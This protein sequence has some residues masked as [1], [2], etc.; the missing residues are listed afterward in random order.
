M[1]CQ[2]PSVTAGAAVAAL[3]AASALSCSPAVRDLSPVGEVLV[4]VDTDMPV[5]TVI[6]R[7]RIDLYAPDGSWF[8]SR[9]V[10]R[11]RKTDWPTSFGV[12]LPDPSREGSVVVRLR[13]YLDGEVRD[14]RG[15][16]YVAP[17]SGGKPFEIAAPAGPVVDARL[18]RADGSDATPKTE[19]EP[20]TTIDRL[21]LVRVRPDV[22]AGVR[23]VL[24]G[25]CVGT[26]A[27]VAGGQSCTD[28][29][30]IVAPIT[31]EPTREDTSLAP[32]SVAGTFGTAE[33][34]TAATR[35]AGTA[36]DGT[37]LHDDDVCV[38]G[39]MFVYGSK[40]AFGLGEADDVPRRV[41]IVP[42]FRIDRYE[43][44][45]GRFRAAVAKGFV[46]PTAPGVALTGNDAPLATVGIDTTSASLC[47]WS[48]A[49]RG[50][51]TF[52]I[53]CLAW[54]IARAFCK[55]DGGDLPSE[56]QW[57]YVAANAGRPFQSRYPWGGDDRTVV[58]CEQTAFGRGP[59]PFDNECNMDG[60]TF[61]LLPVGS[62]TGALADV[63]V[64]LG[65]VDLAGGLSE[66]TADAFAS[67]SSNCWTS[68]PL[69][70]PAC[71]VE[72]APTHTARGGN[73]STSRQSLFLAFRSPFP[74]KGSSPSVGFRCVHPGQ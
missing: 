63:S 11:S 8:E 70:A 45:V 65:V 33:R 7:L 27:D 66:F 9:D 59:Y 49:P 44:T 73:W 25:A 4:I 72:P 26:M 19:P 35:A 22:H 67:L 13:G 5:P 47:T 23:V 50:R 58:R 12:F 54:P 42:P 34:C 6:N 51:E 24:R 52:A 46:V 14:Y 21:V 69:V 15:E 40:D 61:G 64:G 38:D 36:P 62:R 56:A 68:Q 48:D 32:P 18:I 37:P 30:A 55:F 53:N 10:G 28:T 57:E 2:S 60:S 41:A 39:A 29:G 17:S 3:A 20:A 71:L 74:T 43:V 16:R 1:R 31:P